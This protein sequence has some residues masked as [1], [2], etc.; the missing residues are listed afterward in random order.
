MRMFSDDE[1][2][3][4]W[5]AA[6]CSPNAM[7]R[8]TGLHVRNIYTRRDSLEGK[9]HSLKT[10]PVVYEKKQEKRWTIQSSIDLDVVGGSVL[11]CSDLHVWPGEIPDMWRAFCR[12]AH[13][14]KPAAIVLAGDLIDG[15]RIS[16]HPRLRNQ[17]PPTVSEEVG[18]LRTWLDMLPSGPKFWT[19]GNHDVRVSNYIANMAPELADW[20]GSLEDRFPEYGF[21]YG[22]VINGNTEIRHNFRSG[23]SA[24]WNNVLHSGISICTG[25]TH[26]LDVKSMVDRRGRRY[27]VELGMIQA[28]EHPMFEY[29][30]GMVRRWTQGFALL[31]FDDEGEL[32]PPELCQATRGR[33]MFR[34]Y[35]ILAPKPKISLRGE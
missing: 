4:A 11:V 28:P 29:S 31:S 12:V 14:L 8:A 17:D 26:Q 33:P 1:W 2:L 23:V 30:M 34:G 16:R 18:A 6:G 21:A 10:A 15:T 5:H 35:D 22:V 3:A 9:G 20:C 7:S 27:G 13:Y 25:H 24:A 32:M 19:P